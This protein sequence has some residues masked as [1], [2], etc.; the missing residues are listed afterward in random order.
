M[1]AVQFAIVRHSMTHDERNPAPRLRP[2]VAWRALALTYFVVT[3]L[4]HVHNNEHWSLL[5]GVI[6]GTHELAHVVFSPF[7]E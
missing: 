5:S 3:A 4:R 1:C 2:A 6:L 7:G